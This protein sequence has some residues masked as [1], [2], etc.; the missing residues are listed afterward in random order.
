MSEE[1]KVP[2]PRELLKEK[3]DLLGVE[4]KSNV[5]DAK[6]LELIE[7]KMKPSVKEVSQTE[8][9]KIQAITSFQHKSLQKLKR[10]I[11]TCNDPQMRE[12]DSTPFY[13]VS[14]ALITL[15]KITIPLNVEWHCPAAYY[16]LLK[17]QS[18]G[19][20][21]KAKDGKGRT[22]TVRKSIKKYNIQDLPDLTMEELSELKQMQIMR[23]GVA[24]ES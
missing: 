7:A 19:I 11:I 8:E 20:A 16:N 5:T 2:T 21:V 6:L 13:S 23:E 10:V 22:V 15:P 14:N 18:C 24:K 17:E 12:W 4:Y 1:T 3:A 9:E